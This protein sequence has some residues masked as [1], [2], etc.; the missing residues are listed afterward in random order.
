MK[1]DVATPDKLAFSGTAVSVSLIAEKGQLTILDRHCDLV[2]SLYPGK[3]VVYK[4]DQTEAVFSI[5]G[6]VLKV[7]GGQLTILTT[8]VDR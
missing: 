2:T 3:V 5:S 1:V 7:E 8:K 6:G 4:P